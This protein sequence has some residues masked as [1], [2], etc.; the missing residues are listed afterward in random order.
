[1][2]ATVVESLEGGLWEQWGI[3][4]PEHWLAWQ[5]GMTPAHARQFV[6]TARRA[7][8]LPSTGSDSRWW[9]RLA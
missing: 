4:S 7:S 6:D 2:V 5:T 8:E 9:W 3:R 1:L